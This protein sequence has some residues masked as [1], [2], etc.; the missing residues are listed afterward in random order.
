[1]GSELVLN[2]FWGSMTSSE[3]FQLNSEASVSASSTP[4]G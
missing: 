4:V 1:M 3:G 2:S